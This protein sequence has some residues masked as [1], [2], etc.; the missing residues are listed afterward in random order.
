MTILMNAAAFFG[1]LFAMEAVAYF[2]HKYVMHGFLWVLHE[3][4]HQERKGLFEKNDWF[5][6]MFA[7][8]SILLIY[9]GTNGTP[10]ALWAG[11]GVAAYGLVYFVFHDVIVHRRIP[12]NWRPKGKYMRRIIFAHRHHHA[13]NT[14]DGAVSFGFIYAPSVPVLRAQMKEMTTATATA[15]PSS[16]P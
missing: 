9:L 14:K 10:V 2:S 13:I 5:A 1:A 6:V 3:S 16:R 8:P 4:H 11:L 12:H 7:T 15:T